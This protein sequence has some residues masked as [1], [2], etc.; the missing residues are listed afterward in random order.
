MSPGKGHFWICDSCIGGVIWNP[1]QSTQKDESEINKEALEKSAVTSLLDSNL[2][3]PLTA[4]VFLKLHRALTRLHLHLSPEVLHHS[5]QES[6]QTCW[7]RL[8]SCTHLALVDVL[9]ELEASSNFMLQ[10]SVPQI[11]GI[12]IQLPPL[13]SCVCTSYAI[14]YL[15]CFFKLGHFKT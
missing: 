7:F 8:S 4:L 6:Q 13:L 2:G 1:N 9:L 3:Q 10:S 14:I 15:E 5:T 12:H 11:L